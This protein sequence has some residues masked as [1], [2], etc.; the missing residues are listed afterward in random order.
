[1][2]VPQWQPQPTG[3]KHIPPTLLTQP[4]ITVAQLNAS[5]QLLHQP[6][7][8]LQLEQLELW[9][10]QVHQAAQGLV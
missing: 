8:Q 5:G 10:S 3:Q 1:M 6:Q 9:C 2:Q 4:S 7:L